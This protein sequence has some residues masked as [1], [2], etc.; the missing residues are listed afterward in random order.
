MT[1]QAG[2]H[3]VEPR[4]RPR[5]G[6]VIAF[7]VLAVLVTAAS[8][9][10][11]EHVGRP[12]MARRALIG[13]LP[14][15]K[16]TEPVSA[17]V[18]GYRAFDTFGETFILLAAVVGVGLL[19]R[20]RE[21][22]AGYV[23]EEAAGARE[24]RQVRVGEHGTTVSEREAL[25]AEAAEVGEAPASW[26]PLPDQ[27][28]LGSPGPER[29]AAMTVVVRAGVRVVAP[30]LGVAGIY[31]FAWGYSPGGGFPGG[32][33]ALGVILLMYVSVG[34]RRIRPALRSD[35]VE[36]VELG[37][38]VLIV[39][40]A[41]GGLIAA[42]SVTTNFLPLAPPETI[43]SGGTLQAFS[44]AE[45][46]EVATGLTLATLALLGMGHDWSTHDTEWPTQ[47]G[48]TSQ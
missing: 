29:A 1:H 14:D 48:R 10:P 27:E 34:Y 24:Q 16:S 45:F 28:P 15:W 43:R 38:A 33:V 32:A 8:L 18:Y 7:G 2:L 17:I 36:P 37:G 41:V 44:A 6:L 20:R 5:T 47:D 12:A 19:C 4:H 13:A 3:E 40:I 9:L 46:V 42:G 39:L 26:P 31:L 11:R 35:I 25:R 21:P 23:G 30:I 22:H